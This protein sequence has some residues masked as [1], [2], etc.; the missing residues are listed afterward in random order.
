MS[1]FSC[2]NDKKQ[3][4]SE[5]NDWKVFKL[6]GHVKRLDETIYSL[7]GKRFNHVEFSRTGNIVLQSS[8]NDDSTLIKRWEYEYKNG[9]RTMRRCYVSHDSLSQVIHYYYNKNLKIDSICMVRNNGQSQKIVG[10]YYDLNGNIIKE[11]NFG[12]DSKLQ[13]QSEFVYNN[14]NQV[15][16]MEK[17][18]F[19]FH[20]GLKQRFLYD[21]NGRKV[22]ESNYSSKDDKLIQFRVFH[23]ETSD[24]P[25][26]VTTYNRNNKISETIKYAYDNNENVSKIVTVDSV[27]VERE[28]KVKYWYDEYRNW[29]R[30][31]TYENDVADIIIE[32]K[33]DYYSE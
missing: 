16:E 22:K 6:Q 31:V 17:F 23:Y 25:V 8:F 24:R 20:R 11:L 1:L 12:V 30:M 27:Q 5:M 29:K 4:S 18:N 33:L 32:R 2:E 28:Q 7:N 26:V 14:L 15:K 13:S 3:T 9:M 19:V 21:E 10:K